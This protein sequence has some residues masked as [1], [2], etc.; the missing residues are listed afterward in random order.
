[1]T[2]NGK[3]EKVNCETLWEVLQGIGASRKL[4]KDEKIFLYYLASHRRFSTFESLSSTLHGTGLTIQ[5]FEQVSAHLV[6]LELIH[7]PDHRHAHPRYELR[8]RAF[9]RY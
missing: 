9:L 3:E 5:E 6:D 7:D 4:T 2:V 8:V 1:M